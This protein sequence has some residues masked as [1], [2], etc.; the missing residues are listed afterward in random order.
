MEYNIA[1]VVL[2]RTEVIE[3]RFRDGPCTGCQTLLPLPR[4]WIG[5]S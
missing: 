5:I 1:G 2:E 4:I 3:K